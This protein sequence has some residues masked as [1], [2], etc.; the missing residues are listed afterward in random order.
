MRMSGPPLWSNGQSSWLQ[1]QRS[2][3]DSRRYLIFWE[4]VGSNGAHS[5]SWV[6]LRSYLGEKKKSSGS[7]LE[8]REYGRR[9][10]SCWPRGTLYPQKLTLTSPTSGGRW[11][12]IVRSRTRATEFFF[13]ELTPS[14]YAAN[15]TATREFPDILSNRKIHYRVHKSPPLV[16]ILSQINPV[17]TTSST[18]IQSM[19]R[20]S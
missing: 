7:G 11:N 3:L 15:Y 17:P 5:A 10:P 6:Q 8:I 12:G 2:G 13:M 9:D 1:I 18:S 14:R 20:S 4:V 19:S 16:P